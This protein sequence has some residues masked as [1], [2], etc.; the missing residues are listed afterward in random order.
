M[1]NAQRVQAALI[2]LQTVDENNVADLLANL[3]HYARAKR[4][5]F[6]ALME[7]ARMHYD[8]ERKERNPRGTV[9]TDYKAVCGQIFT[10][11]DGVEWDSDTTSAI[12]EIITE[13]GYKIRASNEG[14]DE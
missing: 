14:D 2:A 5:D 13:A 1:T 11:L 4:L 3:M 8:A 6:D 7:N 10:Q 9:P 12:A